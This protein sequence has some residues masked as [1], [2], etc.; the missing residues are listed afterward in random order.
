LAACLDGLHEIH[1]RCVAVLGEAM[2][3]AVE[4]Q[5]RFPRARFLDAPGLTV[6]QR[7]QRGV[8]IVPGEFIALLED[9]SI[10]DAG[11]VEAVCA[12]FTRPQVTAVGG[13]VQLAP[14]LAGR[15]LA[16][17][18]GE[19]GRFHPQ[20]MG[21]L[22]TAPVSAEGGAPVT[23]L[24]GNNLAYRRERL[25]QFLTA[26]A[27]GLIETEINATLRAQNYV[28]WMQPGM[29]VVYAAADRHNARLTTRFHHGRLFAG[30]RVAG[31]GWGRRVT[32]FCQSLLLPAVLTVRA[33]SHM[34]YAVRPAAWPVVAGWILLMESTWAVG[35]S[36]GYL[37]GAGRSLE[38]WR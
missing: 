14:R 33:W 23:R 6:P 26:S 21:L 29:S 24:P 36:V 16:L 20:R 31:C 32:W 12:G 8:E 28:L 37:F 22:A 30:A 4:W 38:V 7:R 3:T 2:G 18:C 17:G 13:P 15:F 11:W 34:R 10:P 9:T 25:Q 5:R 27:R 1:D 19:Y 35:E